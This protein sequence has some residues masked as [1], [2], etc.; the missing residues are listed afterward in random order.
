MKIKG[1]IAIVCVILVLSIAAPA[2]SQDLPIKELQNIM[3]E[4]TGNLAKSLPFNSSMGLNWADAYIGKFPRFGVGFSVG[5]TTMDMGSFQKLLDIFAPSLPGWLTGSGDNPGFGGFPIPGYAVEGRL[6]GFVLPFDIG[7]KF[8]H[9][10]IKVPR[11]KNFDYTLIGGDFRYAV[12]EGNAVLP[13][14]S[15]G[16]GFNYLSG[17]LGMN[18]GKDRPF[19]YDTGTPV[20]IITATM[21]AP[22]IT[23]DWST[24]SLDFKAQI[25][26]SFVFITPYLGVGASTGWSK[27]GFNVKMKV[28][29][30][31]NLDDLK[32]IFKAIG[33]DLSEKGFS[34]ETDPLNGW[35]FRLFGGLTFNVAVVRIELTGF[36]NFIDKYG[37]TFG[38][39]VQL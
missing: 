38:L 13:T 5:L 20:G 26:K 12:L 24:A 4:F 7:I 19:S 34:S 21:K 9:M 18:A 30:G 22:E 17:A 15:V 37:A 32:N 31:D 39:R 28:E 1:K 11:L 27:A 6:G 23:V 10:P 36:Y 14:V 33:I 3:D 35:S 8:G 29:T 16:V 2:F 25:S